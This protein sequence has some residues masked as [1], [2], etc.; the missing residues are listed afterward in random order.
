MTYCSR[1]SY[2]SAESLRKSYLRFADALIIVEQIFVKLI[3]SQISDIYMTWK[4]I[5]LAAHNVQ[6]FYTNF[7]LFSLL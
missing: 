3:V 4:R 7:N 1:C 5:F 2:K 6:L